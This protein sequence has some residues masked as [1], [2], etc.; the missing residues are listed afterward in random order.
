MQATSLESRIASLVHAQFDSL[1]RGSK[2]VIRDNGVREWIP[3]S[4]IV[5]VCSMYYVFLSPSSII[6][7]SIYPIIP[8]PF[9][10]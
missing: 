10:P 5:L 9:Y 4:G 1:P 6:I 3:M 2:P 7:D 8:R